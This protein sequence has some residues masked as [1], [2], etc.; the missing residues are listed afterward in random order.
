MH[1]FTYGSLM[2]APVWL[3]ATGRGDIGEVATLYGHRRLVVRGETYP[4]LVPAAADAPAARVDGI[5]YRDLDEADLGRLDAFE[6]DWYRRETRDVI[7]G[8]TRETAQVYLFL[9]PE[10]LEDVDWSVDD[11]SR[12]GLGR[13]I[14][15]YFG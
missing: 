5:L 8:S 13:F 15:R 9:R 12:D 11:F 4:G 7:V 14:E 3:R 2:F 10:L 6:G 1:L